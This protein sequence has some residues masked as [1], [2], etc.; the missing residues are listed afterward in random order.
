MPQLRFF[1]CGEP[2]RRQSRL[3][4]LAGFEALAA[5]P[6]ALKNDRSTPSAEASAIAAEK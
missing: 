5:Q 2:S 1:R 3:N 4:H 6:N